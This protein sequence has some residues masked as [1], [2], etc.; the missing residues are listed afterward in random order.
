MKTIPSICALLCQAMP[1]GLALALGC[2][3]PA[4]AENG[5]VDGPGSATPAV[6]VFTLNNP[7]PARNE[8]F[9]HA[10]AISGAR[11]VVGVPGIAG[12]GTNPPA[13]GAYVYD[14]AGPA[15]TQPVAT[16]PGSTSDYSGYAV[17]ISGQRV[18]VGENGGSFPVPI[19]GKATVRD[20]AGGGAVVLRSPFQT[21]DDHYG[22]A[23]AISG[24][25]VVVGASGHIF[26]AVRDIGRAYVYDLASGTPTVPVATL[27]NPSPTQGDFFGYAVAIS[28]T[29]VVVGAY[30]DETGAPD[31]GSAYVYDLTSGTPAVP[32]ATLPNP[33]PVAQDQ[34][35]SAVAISGTRVVVGS[36]GDDTGAFAAGSA[37][38]YDLANAT[39]AVPVL[40][41][42][43]PDPVSVG[44]FGNSV[45][46]SDGRVV[47]GA[48]GNAPGGSA[49]VYALDGATPT[50][51]VAALHNPGPAAGDSFGWSVAIDGPT[52][53]IGTPFDYNAATDNGSVYVFGP[54]PLDQDS[55]GLLDSWELSYWPSTTGHGPLD[56]EDHDGYVDL[57]E[58]ALG[59]N[60][61]IPDHASL[62]TVE[63]G[64]LT[65]TLTKHPGATYQVQS[66]GTLLPAQPESFSASSTTMLID[67]PTTLKVRDNIPIGTPPSRFLRL[68][69]TAAP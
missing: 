10:V 29:R 56:D 67:N 40:T 19:N 18:V 16:F 41:L 28:G 57:L 6:P 50:V 58:L 48:Y 49:Y 59:L 39:P 60:P 22:S 24:T 20:L 21:R 14:L 12:A 63:G 62:L 55:D 26:G 46:I 32:V 45:A 36:V 27:E 30:G 35:G 9:G 52:I 34:F 66:A 61:T 8:L 11:L 37:Y 38:V 43:N 25:R 17:A 42:H 13:G 64:Y 54:H 5:S 47:I 69:V 68:K 31:A 7:S 4:G 2:L 33:H 65:M 53:A 23:V 44:L 51:P 15:P 1:A 3:A